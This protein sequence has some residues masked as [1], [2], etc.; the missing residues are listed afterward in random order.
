MVDSQQRTPVPEPDVL[1]YGAA[2]DLA[3]LV[4]KEHLIA[5]FE[6]KYERRMKTLKENYSSKQTVKHG[7]I[8]DVTEVVGSQSM[9]DPRDYPQD[10]G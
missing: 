6:S 1:T 7:R 9:R 5:T 4:G 2:I 8:K 3:P 10:I